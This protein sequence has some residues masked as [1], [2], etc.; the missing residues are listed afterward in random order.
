MSRDI[1]IWWASTSVG[2]SPSTVFAKVEEVTYPVDHPVGWLNGLAGS[3]TGQPGM[4]ALW[5]SPI[6]NPPGECTCTQP[7]Y[8]PHHHK[9]GC[10]AVVERRMIAAVMLVNV[11]YIT[12]S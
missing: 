9:R 6:Y 4:L 10:P 5:G 7:I 1:T 11:R 8:Q 12:V 2:A 3:S